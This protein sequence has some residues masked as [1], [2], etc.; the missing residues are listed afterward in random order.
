MPSRNRARCCVFHWCSAMAQFT[1]V[2]DP[3]SSCF[4]LV[5]YIHVVHA[6]PGNQCVYSASCNI[7]H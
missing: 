4:M 1:A 7:H 2:T 5:K 3:L 6:K